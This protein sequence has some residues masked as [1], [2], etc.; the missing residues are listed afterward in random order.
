MKKFP[1]LP[2][3]LFLLSNLTIHA[4]NEWTNTADM[5]NCFSSPRAADLN[6]DGVLDIVVGAGLEDSVRTNGVLAFD[7][8]NGDLLWRVE[9]RNQMY[10]S[11][12][13]YDISGD[14]TAD[15]FIGGRQAQ[16]Y[17]IN[18]ATGD[19]IWEYYPEGDTLNPGPTADLYNFYN[20]Q[21]VPD[22]DG[23][24]YLDLFV[25]NGGDKTAGIFDTLRPA[26]HLMVINSRTGEPFAM[27]PVPD[28]REVYMSPLVHDFEADGILDVIYGTG[29]ETL[30]G[31]LWR[32]TLI[33]VLDGDLSNSVQLLDGGEKGM[34]AP[35]SLADLNLDG[36]QDIII[37]A[38]DNKAV[39]I[40]GADNSILWEVEIPGTETIASPAIGQFTADNVPDVF[41]IYGVGVA[42]SF[43]DFIQLMID[44]ASGEIL[45][46][47]TIGF[48]SFASPVAFDYDNDGK[49]EAMFCVS[50]IVAP[51]FYH[52][53]LLADFNDDELVEITGFKGGSNLAST[54]LV[55]DLDEDGSLEIVYAHNTDSTAFYSESGFTIERLNLAT[56]TPSNI[57][58]GAYMG[59]NYDGLYT[60]KI[61]T[62]ID[63]TAPI[64]NIDIY[65]N[66]TYGGIAIKATVSSPKK[67][68]VKVYDISGKV[69]LKEKCSP[70]DGQV[71]HFLDLSKQPKGVYFVEMNLNQEAI[72]HKVV[73]Q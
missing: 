43:V 46:Q 32:T 10:G 67:M 65:P 38:Y 7:G 25:A 41:T 55:A 18:G 13:L 26:G 5:V 57:A 11:A 68:T 34:I 54:P 47:D 23:D 35:P 30:P 37:N 16:L 20:C 59:T 28:G 40:S 6:S 19:I 31:A 48:W 58:W 50:D 14:G 36:V 52:K 71:Q 73:V 61:A 24:G 69:V 8:A 70:V 4:Q 1:L 17:A 64:Y 39:A 29:G 33:E 63:D 2:F 21:L 62:G 9:A 51:T 3:V 72:R 12:L 66:P 44:G 56:S 49:D 27:T 60:P 53:L 22:E 45:F 42:P 15:V